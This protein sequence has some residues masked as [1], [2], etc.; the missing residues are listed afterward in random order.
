MEFSE[1]I[2]LL[3]GLF[4]LIFTFLFFNEVNL[5][6]E[7]TRK[8]QIYEFFGGFSFDHQEKE[9]ITEAPDHE[10]VQAVEKLFLN[11]SN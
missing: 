4:V 7:L 6:F 1:I 11:R 10:T 8:T 9:N 2:R 3:F 5:I